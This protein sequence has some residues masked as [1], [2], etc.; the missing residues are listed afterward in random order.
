MYYFKELRKQAKINYHI[1][2]SLSPAPTK[3][4]VTYTV[5]LLSAVGYF[6]STEISYHRCHHSIL[7][8]GLFEKPM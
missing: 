6:N 4:A 8:I 3:T 1:K 5:G 2:L 7:P